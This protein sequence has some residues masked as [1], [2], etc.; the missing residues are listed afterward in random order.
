MIFGSFIHGDD[1]IFRTTVSEFVNDTKT[2]PVVKYKAFIAVFLF[3]LSGVL[4]LGFLHGGRL[5]Q[6]NSWLH[7]FI[8]VSGI[9]DKYADATDDDDYNRLFNY[10]YSDTDRGD[11]RSN[12]MSGAA[13][14][15]K[16]IEGFDGNKK[17][18]G[19]KDEDGKVTNKN[20][21]FA[22]ADVKGAEKASAAK[23]KTPCAT[24]CGQYVDIKGQINTL[25]KMVDAVQ[26]QKDSIKQ[27]ADAIQAVGK[28]IEDL[29]KSLSPGGQV[30]IQL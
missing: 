7:L 4:I 13:V 19:S 30:N 6:H 23:K 3:A 5:L 20:G 14:F 2:H 12:N 27:N 18:S 16:A 9:R 29:N 1:N 22:S 17:S 8:P 21:G 15:R 10:N 11:G 26:D 25:S 28:Q 24:D